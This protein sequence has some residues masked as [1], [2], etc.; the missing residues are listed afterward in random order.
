MDETY[1]TSIGLIELETKE[2]IKCANAEI[3]MSSMIIYITCSP[4]SIPVTVLS[5]R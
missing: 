4:F 2:L 5:Y 3:G 1:G